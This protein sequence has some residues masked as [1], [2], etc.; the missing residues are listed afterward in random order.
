MNAERYRLTVGLFPDDSLNVHDV[1]ETVDGYDFAFAA[2]VGSSS[3]KN[4]V[5]FADRDRSDLHGGLMDCS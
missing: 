5:V 3:Y 1:F 4:F 2:F